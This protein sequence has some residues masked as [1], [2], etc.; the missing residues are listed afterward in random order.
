MTGAM[1]MSSAERLAALFDHLGI[2]RAHVATQVPADIAGLARG[3]P[4]RLAGIVACVPT[5]LDP[6]PFAGVAGQLLMISGASGPTVGATTRAAERLAGAERVVLQ[7]YDAPGW[8][9][10]AVDRGDALV[11]A[12]TGFFDRL[13][14]RGIAADAPR[15][16]ARA[17]THAGITWRVEGSGPALVLLPFFLAPSQWAPIVPRLAARYS[18]VVLGGPHLGG[19]AALEDRARAPTYRAMFGTLIYTLAPSESAA[20]LDVGCG[21]GS[22]DRLLA[23]RLTP[24][25]RLTALDTNPFL[26]REAQALAAADGLD[27]RIRFVEGNAEKLPFDDASF[28]CAFSITVLEECDADRAIGELMR[29]V[30]PGGRV[31]VIV[32]AIDMPQWWNLPAPEDIRRKIDVPPQSVGATGVADASLYRRMR[33]AG[34]RDLVCFPTLVTLDRPE[35]PIWR[36]RED[37]V[38]SLL[39]P[40]EIATWHELTGTARDEGLLFMGHPMH[41]AVGTR[42][43]G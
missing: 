42:P 37:H 25:Q 34:L 9:D 38:L 24:G 27:G 32:R 3:A 30:R 39:A 20:I 10:V 5:R 31:G 43:V 16:A 41:C 12:M 33:R 23:R 22:L 4:A 19:V 26:L 15:M 6:A 17:G 8:A 29:V 36:Y 1:E 11:A 40:D 13:A 28:E 14:A 21:A 2:G 18:V 35:G 7:G